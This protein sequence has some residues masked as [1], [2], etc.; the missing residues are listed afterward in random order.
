VLLIVD[1]HVLRLS[2]IINM[3]LQIIVVTVALGLLAWW[4][5]KR[6]STPAPLPPGPAGDPIIGHVRI[7]PTSRPE[8]SYAKWGKEYSEQPPF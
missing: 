6:S 8:L 3:Y 1:T 2:S 4:A 7:V 5:S